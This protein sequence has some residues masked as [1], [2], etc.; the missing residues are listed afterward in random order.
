MGRA[1]GSALK[2]MV[3]SVD[4][5]IRETARFAQKAGKDIIEIDV[6]DRYEDYRSEYGEDKALTALQ[7][8]LTSFKKL[9]K[10]EET[11]LFNLVK[12]ECLKRF[13]VAPSNKRTLKAELRENPGLY[14]SVPAV[15]D[16][17]KRFYC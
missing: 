6:R 16:Y 9:A 10:E 8:T 17:V 2:V 12:A 4:R 5:L 14:R 15:R 11:R 1:G 3:K 13:G 7:N